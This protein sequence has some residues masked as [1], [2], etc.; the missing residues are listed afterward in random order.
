[1]TKRK[2]EKRTNYN[3]AP[4]YEF[5]Y[6]CDQ[7]GSARAKT[8]RADTVLGGDQIWVLELRLIQSSTDDK[9]F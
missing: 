1:M 5:L 8:L 6:S 7:I 3:K 2:K 9:G 4:N